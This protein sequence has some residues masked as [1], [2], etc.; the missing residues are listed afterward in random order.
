MSRQLFPAR[1][2]QAKERRN[3]E[4]T[5]APLY[6]ARVPYKADKTGSS[7]SARVIT[8]VPFNHGNIRCSWNEDG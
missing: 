8:G 5:I 1:H 6:I 4:L 7:H 2:I 3:P